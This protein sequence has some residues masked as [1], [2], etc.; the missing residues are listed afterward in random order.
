MSFCHKLVGDGPRL[1][2]SFCDS[3]HFCVAVSTQEALLKEIE[4]S[5]TCARSDADGANCAAEVIPHDKAA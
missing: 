1:I 3:C 5:H 2:A 4:S